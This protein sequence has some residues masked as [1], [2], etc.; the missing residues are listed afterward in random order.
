MKILLLNLLL[1][2]ANTG[3][4]TTPENY[5]WLIDELNQDATVMTLT[6][7]IENKVKF[8]DE[9]GNLVQ[10]ISKTDFEENNMNDSEIKLVSKSVFM[11]DYLGDSY[12]LLED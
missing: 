3:D 2:V 6:A 12:F 1:N 8:F 11:F 9:A 4:A 10:E 7:N 5:Q